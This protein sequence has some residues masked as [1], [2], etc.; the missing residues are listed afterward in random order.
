MDFGWFGVAA[1]TLLMLAFAGFAYETF[2]RSRT[3]FSGVT[4]AVLD[5][6]V[7]FSFFANLLLT[8]G[9]VFQL[10][11][12]VVVRKAVPLGREILPASSL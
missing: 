7:M 1:F 9:V 5:G 3:I 11:I 8:L 6:I 4:L 2:V 10:L 12:L